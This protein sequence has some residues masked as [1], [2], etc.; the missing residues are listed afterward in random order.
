M[1]N[2]IGLRTAAA[3]LVAGVKPT[4]LAM[5][6]GDNNRVFMKKWTVTL[7]DPDTGVTGPV[8][9]AEV[10]DEY[11]L[12]NNQSFV[13]TS[14]VATFSKRKQPMHQWLNAPGVNWYD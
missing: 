6:V 12:W 4:L 14:L 13:F 8:E 7:Q 9:V 3:K 2:Y 11:V 1:V 10:V 5:I